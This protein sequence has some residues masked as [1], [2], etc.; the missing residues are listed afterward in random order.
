MVNPKQ[1]RANRGGGPIVFTDFD[2]TI[3]QLDVTDE[4]LAQLAHPSWQEIEQA[5]TRGLIGSR[6]CLERQIALV[7]ASAEEL[8]ALIDAVPID[9]AF[10]AFYRFTRKRS[11]PLYVL[12]EGFDYV[13]ARILKRAG[14]N[15]PVRNG[16]HTFS[17]ALRLEG[18][19]LIPSFP[20]SAQPCEHGCATCKAAL[21]R[22]FGKGKYPVIFVGDGLSDRFAVDEADVVFAKRQLLAYCQ[23]HGKPC[24]PFD[25]FAEVE[26]AI[27]RLIA[28]EEAAKEGVRSTKSNA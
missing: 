18:R 6:E 7:D 25:T 20:H 9:P 27:A 24:H 4:I 16:I 5:W 17:S 21:I 28:R 3:T 11:I 2:G 13:I 12:S 15:G 8:H 19:R 26:Q 1:A 14:M 23:E 10:S 22:R